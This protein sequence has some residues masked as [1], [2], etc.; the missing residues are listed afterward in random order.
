MFAVVCLHFH[1]SRV[2][3]DVDTHHWC[4]AVSETVARATHSPS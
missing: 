1:V 4:K 2:P 3:R